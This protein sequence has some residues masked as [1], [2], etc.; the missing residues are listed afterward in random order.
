MQGPAKRAPIDHQDQNQRQPDPDGHGQQ[1][2]NQAHQPG[3]GGHE[4]PDL[5]GGVAGCAQYP[6]L[7]RPFKLEGHQRTQY[8]DEGHHRGEQMKD[9]RYGKSS[10][11]D[12]ERSVA[13]SP[14]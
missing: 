10:I 12:F 8:P 6:K 7:T 4:P 9:G 11:K 14:V 13:Q 3:L 2:G 1:T 5:T